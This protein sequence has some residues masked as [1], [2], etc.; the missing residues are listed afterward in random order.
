[1]KAKYLIFIFIVSAAVVFQNCS[2]KANREE[3]FA[4]ELTETP[5]FDSL[6]QQIDFAYVSD[7]N[8]D[9]LKSLCADLSRA[10]GHASPLQKARLLYWKSKISER[11]LDR[12]S[13]SIYANKG[14]RLIDS[15]DAPYT[16]HRLRYQSEHSRREND[17]SDYAH[18]IQDAEFYRDAG[19]RVMWANSLI[20]TGNILLYCNEP[21]LALAHYWSADSLL[22]ISGHAEPFRM[23]N[24]IN[25]S[26]VLR[27]AGDTAKSDA[28]LQEILR[29]DEL[30][31]T[32]TAFYQILCRNAYLNTGNPAYLR[33]FLASVRTKSDSEGTESFYEGLLSLWH[34]E[35]GSRD[36][37]D[38]YAARALDKIASL[39]NPAMRNVVYEANVERFAAAGRADSALAFKIMADRAEEENRMLQEADNIRRKEYLR[40]I[41]ES[42]TEEERKR[43]H[44]R[45]IFT[46]ATSVLLL[47]IL[48]GTGIVLHRRRARRMERA[49][50]AL[51]LERSRYQAALQSLSVKEAENT[52]SSLASGISELKDQK[53]IAPRDARRLTD[54]VRIHK[55]HNP[56]RESFEMLYIKAEPGLQIAL[57]ERWPALTEGQLRLC[58]YLRAGLN[59]KQISRLMMVKP[60]SV[61]QAKRRLRRTM[62]LTDSESLEDL[63]RKL[64]YGQL[65]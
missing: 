18:S 50:L 6:S 35:K 29:H 34:R 32:D 25:I 12:D 64:A 65:P 22:R 28:V 15:A 56:E 10:A 4:W 41:Y 26:T 45:Q 36:S 13:A 40:I 27:M 49:T 2:D 57:K 53:E 24:R 8:S 30:C 59:G 42:K 38:F 21:L 51:E 55:S 1:M 3:R 44:E 46:V 61:K 5:T 17:R 9:S 37:A 14:L 54:I 39:E 31:R 23:K 11:S 58:Y 52:I 16:F 20:A 7:A 48:A 33:K 63:L 43:M 60:E 19:D 62:G 47:A